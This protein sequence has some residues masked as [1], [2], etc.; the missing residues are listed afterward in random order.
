MHFHLSWASGADTEPKAQAER[1]TSI[2]HGLLG[3]D[4]EPKARA[5]RCTS[6]FHGPLGPTQSPRHG[7]KD[8][9]PSFMGLWSLAAAAAAASGH[10]QQPAT[11]NSSHSKPI[12]NGRKT[13]L[14][15][16]VLIARQSRTGQRMAGEGR[17]EQSRP[18]ESFA[19]A[20]EV[21]ALTSPRESFLR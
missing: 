19:P 16:T 3:A 21:S 13:P 9:L 17:A 4:T 14:K 11:G 12:F 18:E 7:L 1:C 2:F 5:E 10:Q 8:A 6:I 15:T 20:C